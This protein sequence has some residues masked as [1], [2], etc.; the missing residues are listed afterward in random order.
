[1]ATKTRAKLD[2]LPEEQ[3]D[4]LV[5]WLSIEGVTYTEAQNRL[6]DQFG[7]ETSLSPLCNFYQ[8]HC[9]GYR[10]RRA[11]KLAKEVGA[12]WSEENTDFSAN[13]I[14]AIEQQ[15]FELSMAK[16]C[17]VKELA[18]LSGI[19]GDTRKMDL[20][21]RKLEHDERRIAILEKKAGMFDEIVEAANDET[22]SDAEIRQRTI[23]AVDDIL[24]PN[25][26]AKK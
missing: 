26:G 6:K 12:I 4:Q 20:Q 24:M 18:V 7:V 25:K 5:D 14:K 10:H 19:L 23:A 1:M 2:K 22:L 11:R 16:D 21:E 8:R 9:I 3:F 15:A 13:T 17:S